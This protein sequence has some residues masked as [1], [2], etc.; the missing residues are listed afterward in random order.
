DL[1]D[2]ATRVSHTQQK[3]SSGKELTR[4]SDDPFATGR[5]IG[6]RTE[7]EGLSQ[8]QR[9]V[10]D[11][12][13]W[14][15]VSENAL[16]TI[17]DIVHSARE[18]LLR[19][20]TGTTSAGER[21]IIADEID[22]LISAVKDTANATYA[23]RSLFSGSATAT[24]PYGTA[25]DAYLGDGGDVVRSIGPGVSVVVNA[26]GSDMLGDGTDGK[27]LN[28]LRDISAHLRGGTAADMAAL[29][30]SDLVAIDRSLDNVLNVRAQVGSTASRLQAAT[31]RLAEIEE[32]VRGLLSKTE[33]ADMAATMIDYS[34]Q[35]SVYQSALRAGAGIVQASLLDFLR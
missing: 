6:L 19:G 24:K 29:G 26:R 27:L 4:P 25:S 17:T 5:A 35:Q 22:S 28:A 7:L 8:Y 21:N 14:T 10:D 12:A 3:L 34:M 2:I 16:G 1:N 30:G 9:N 11:A 31:G 13:A 23:G 20:S 15:S 33:D 18:L 32:G